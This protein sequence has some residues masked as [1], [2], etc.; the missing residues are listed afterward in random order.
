MKWINLIPLLLLVSGC[1]S[2]PPQQSAEPEA[3]VESPAKTSIQH[4]EVATFASLMGQD[5][6][7]VLDVRTPAEIAEGKIENALEIDI[8]DQSFDSQIQNLDKHKSYLVYCKKGGRSAR[9]C[10]KMA[11]YGFTAL[12]NL[13][14]GYTAWAAAQ[15]K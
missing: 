3:A 6:V 14:G 12:Y 8:M 10:E 1:Q 11:D 15:E 2:Q 13:K 9:A 5:H 4:V 7:V